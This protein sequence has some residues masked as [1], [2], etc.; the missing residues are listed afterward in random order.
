MLSDGFVWKQLLRCRIWKN[1][2][3]LV[4][5]ACDRNEPSRGFHLVI[6]QP[7]HRKWVLEI[8]CALRGHFYT[9]QQ[10]MSAR[11][12]TLL[13]W[14]KKIME[15]SFTFSLLGNIVE[16]LSFL[17]LSL[18]NM[19]SFSTEEKPQLP[20]TWRQ[21]R[22]VEFSQD[23]HGDQVRRV[24]SF[25]VF[26]TVK[27]SHKWV[28]EKEERLPLSHSWMEPP[29]NSRSPLTIWPLQPWSGTYTRW[30]APMWSWLHF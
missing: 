1:R 15:N 17:T 2:R 10:H 27:V 8:F 13:I 20:V 11:I 7:R 22:S 29:A 26:W 18:W 12:H 28:E 6:M 3:P 14:G 19:I 24:K 21:N 25:E 30:T 16:L 23:K 4:Q 5:W 9:P